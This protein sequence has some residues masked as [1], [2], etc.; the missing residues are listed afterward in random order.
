MLAHPCLV[1][2]VA[3]VD[4]FLQGGDPL[5]AAIQLCHELGVALGLG[6][7]APVT[8]RREPF[9]DALLHLRHSLADLL[10]AIA[11]LLVGEVDA[12]TAAD[13][14]VVVAAGGGGDAADGERAGEDDAADA[15]GVLHGAIHGWFL[16]I[17]SVVTAEGDERMVRQP[18]EETVR[19][20]EWIGDTGR[21]DVHASLSAPCEPHELFAFVDDLSRYPS[22][23][24]LVHRA[25]PVAG[26]EPPEWEVELRARIGP[27]ARSKRLRMRRSE[28]RPDEG[29]AVFE[30]HEVDGKR[31]APWV[32]RAE[33]EA[34]SAEVATLRMHLHYGGALWTGGVLERTLADQITNGRERL[35]ALVRATR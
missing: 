1:A 33:V 8:E 14:A 7:I 12:V 2:G 15:D 16:S 13:A 22:W 31:H 18:C 19:R 25:E 5:D 21:M 9:G 20:R 30:R 11:L 32:L 26:S 27:L 4:P 6:G 10:L 24:D 35:L 17:P 28:H 3:G 23:V 29:L 34:G